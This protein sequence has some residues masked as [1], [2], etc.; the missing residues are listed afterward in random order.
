MK[1]IIVL[2][3]IFIGVFSLNNDSFAK[4]LSIGEMRIINS[5]FQIVAVHFKGI[6]GR[7]CI[8][9]VEI[10]DGGREIFSDTILFDWE[11]EEREFSAG[12]KKF[13]IFYVMRGLAVYMDG[14]E[15]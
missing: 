6:K 8:V 11:R 15:I 9:D 14:K 1:R 7:S 3:V 4:E 2:A 10:V 13:L 5:D 12:G